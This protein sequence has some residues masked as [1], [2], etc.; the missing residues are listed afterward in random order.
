MRARSTTEDFPRHI[1]PVDFIAA[2][3]CWENGFKWDRAWRQT[4]AR[5]TNA[6]K[7]AAL[8]G[9]KSGHREAASERSRGGL[10]EAAKKSSSNS[11]CNRRPVL[12]KISIYRPDA[13]AAESMPQPQRFVH[14]HQEVS[15]AQNAALGAERFLD[16]SPKRCPYLRPVCWSTSRSRARS[17]PNPSAVA[18]EERQCGR[19]TN[20]SKFRAAT[21]IE[22]QVHENVGFRCGAAQTRF[23]IARFLQI[24]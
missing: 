11:V 2:L 6:L 14:R 10:R 9:A 16:R 8:D 18:R 1:Q 7:I 13:V 24:L 5:E 22:V 4:G 23:F 15:R 20:P 19:G 12:R 17:V 3:S 21:A